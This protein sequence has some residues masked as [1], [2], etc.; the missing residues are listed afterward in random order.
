MDGLQRLSAD[1]LSK[2]K[3]IISVR[4]VPVTL[5][6]DIILRYDAWTKGGGTRASMAAPLP[7]EEEEERERRYA[8]AP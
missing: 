8:S 5:L 7:W 3:W 4:K 1:E 6:K 2:T